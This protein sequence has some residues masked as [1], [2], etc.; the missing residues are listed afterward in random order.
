MKDGGKLE[1]YKRGGRSQGKKRG[2]TLT[3]TSIV[4]NGQTEEG[5]IEMQE[6]AKMAGSRTRKKRIHHYN[7]RGNLFMQEKNS[8]MRMT[9][10]RPQKEY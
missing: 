6:Q 9:K 1:A 4:W 7:R 5:N 2:K 8:R 3:E 10:G